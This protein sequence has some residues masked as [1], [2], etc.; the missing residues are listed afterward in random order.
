M[1]IARAILDTMTKQT[2]TMNFMG[3]L[4]QNTQLS[5]NDLNYVNSIL[6]KLNTQAL[7]TQ[8][9]AQTVLTTIDH[10]FN[11]SGNQAM[12][13][14]VPFDAI[15]LLSLPQ[16]TQQA[17]SSTAIRFAKTNWDQGD[18]NL[19]F[20][21]YFNPRTANLG[22]ATIAEDRTML[23]VMDEYQWVD[24]QEWDVEPVDMP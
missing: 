12:E 15:F 1:S 21:T 20:C 19:Y 4:Q 6:G 5:Q 22:F 17:L 7:T 2:F 24:Q 9:Y 10:I 3:W 18:K 14:S 8:C 23:N 16:A 11:L 13:F